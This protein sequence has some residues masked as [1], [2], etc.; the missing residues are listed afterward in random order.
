M[1]VRM[2]VCDVR[3]Y[4]CIY[5]CTYVCVYVCTIRTSYSKMERSLEKSKDLKVFQGIKSKKKAFDGSLTYSC[6]F[7]GLNKFVRVVFDVTLNV[8]DKLSERVCKFNVKTRF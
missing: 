7:G 2:Y 1:H 3:T 5:V 6:R 4:V 8:S